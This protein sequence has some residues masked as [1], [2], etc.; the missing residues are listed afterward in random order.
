MSN[1]FIRGNWYSNQSRLNSFKFISRLI[2]LGNTS[3]W[4]PYKNRLLSILSSKSSLGNLLILLWLKWRNLKFSLRSEISG[5]IVVIKFPF[6]DK[7]FNLL[8]SEIQAG[9]YVMK[10]WLRLIDWSLGNSWSC[11]GKAV[12]LLFLK[13]TR[14]HLVIST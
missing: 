12:S 10:L 8:N 2:S 1:A 5:Q 11:G 6:T 13:S 14:M 4:F 9:I 7:F 3:K